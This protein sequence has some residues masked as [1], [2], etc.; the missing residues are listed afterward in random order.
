MVKRFSRNLSSTS[1][2]LSPRRPIAALMI[3]SLVFVTP[4]AH[5]IEMDIVSPTMAA[6][7]KGRVYVLLEKEG[8]EYRIKQLSRGL[9]GKT[10][11]QEILILT[12]PLDVSAYVEKPEDMLQSVGRHGAVECTKTAAKKAAVSDDACRSVF[13]RASVGK[14]AASTALMTLVTGGITLVAGMVS[15]LREMDEEE[16]RKAIVTSKLDVCAASILS[17]QGLTHTYE[18]VEYIRARDSAEDAGRGDVE[19]RSPAY[20]T[21]FFIIDTEQGVVCGRS[22]ASALG[23]P[24]EL[25]K[26]AHGYADDGKKL[27]FLKTLNTRVNSSAKAYIDVPPISFSELPPPPVLTKSEY[28]KKSEFDRRVALESEKRSALVIEAQEKYRAD[29]EARNSL[30]ERRL[31]SQSTYARKATKAHLQEVL[32]ELST[33]NPRYDAEKELMYVDLQSTRS[34]F[35]RQMA[36]PIPMAGREAENFKEHLDG[37]SVKATFNVSDNGVL[38]SSVAFY[39]QDHEYLASIAADRFTPERVSILLPSKGSKPDLYQDPNLVDSQSNIA[40]NYSERLSVGAGAVDDASDLVAA[41]PSAPLDKRKWLFLVAIEN[42]KNA[43]PVKFANHSGKLVAQAIQKRFGVSERNSYILI[44]EDA[45]AGAIS[46]QFE[47]MLANIRS[48]DSIYFY[49]SGHGIPDPVS[50]EPYILPRDKIVDF[51]V[52]E[53]KFRLSN[54]Y[55]S[56]TNSAATDIYVFIDSCFSGRTDNVPNFKGVAPGIFRSKE[57]TVASDRIAILTAGKST[58]FSNAF[59]LK[60]NRMF[61]YYLARGLAQP[62]AAYPDVKTLY[63]A[64][65]VGVRESSSAKGDVYFQEPQAYGNVSLPLQ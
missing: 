19:I 53:E 49:Y 11:K 18:N 6:T 31:L 9:P 51:V 26:Q 59:D 56:L 58:Q 33:K 21:P 7:S 28:E 62:K 65:S 27:P 20:A 50:Q 24:P 57:I 46:D 64:I 5:P 37:V 10:E 44:D 4:Y 45:T 39:L 60:G 43:D 47:R 25:E 41:M 1:T 17:P 29:V 8:S 52:R 54:L 32:G 16:I 23:I 15:V 30:L 14:S 12:S 42:Y 55:E 22:L 48:G 13:W 34:D 63:E 61:S 40:L 35:S 36:I 38:L 2:H 3:A